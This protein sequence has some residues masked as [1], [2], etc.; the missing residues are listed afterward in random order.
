MEPE[1][2]TGKRPE[3]GSVSISSVDERSVAF[4]KTGRRFNAA[5]LSSAGTR[6]ARW[7]ASANKGSAGNLAQSAQPAGPQFGE[8]GRRVPLLLPALAR[9]SVE[10]P[11][12]QG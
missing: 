5:S 6:P 7:K 4:S 8:L 1:V 3:A 2:F 10:V 11:H 12:V 9:G